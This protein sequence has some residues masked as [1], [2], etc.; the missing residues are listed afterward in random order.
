MQFIEWNGI[1]VAYTP[2][3]AANGMPLAFLAAFTLAV[4]LACAWVGVQ[5]HM[6]ALTWLAY[7]G[8]SVEIVALYFWT[9]GTLME[10]SLFFLVAGV[11]VCG[12]AGLAWWLHGRAAAV[13]GTAT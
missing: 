7:I 8:F 5:R 9:L 3:M 12:L 1:G 6:R 10:T 2:W 13:E 11:L 4:L